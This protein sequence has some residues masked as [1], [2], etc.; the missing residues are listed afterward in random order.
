MEKYLCNNLSMTK[1]KTFN[2]IHN[3]Y[4]IVYSEI[5]FI[6]SSF[7]FFIFQLRLASRN[8][9]WTDRQNYRQTDIP[10]I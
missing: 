2:Y 8:I 9:G 3:T 10:K 6:W 1:R 5:T 7:Y 4:Y